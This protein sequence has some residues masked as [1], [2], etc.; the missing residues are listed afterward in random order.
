[1]TIRVALSWQP[2]AASLAQLAWALGGVSAGLWGLGALLSRRVC[3]RALQPVIRMA[4]AARALRAD[5]PGQLL[6]VAPSG[7]ELEDLGRAFNDLL[8]RLQEVLERQQRFTGDASH[9]LRTP[10]TAMLGQVEVALRQDRTPDE[11]RRVLQVVQRRAG[12]MSQLVELLLFLARMPAQA[13]LPQTRVV[14]LADWLDEHLRL[15]SDHPRA[16]D[17]RRLRPEEAP[18]G[19]VRIQPALLGQLLD[20]LLDNAC[21]YS[22]PGTPITIRVGRAGRGAELTVADRGHGI[23]PEDLPHVCDPFYRT[24]EA[25]RLGRPGV[26]LGLTVAQR[27]VKALGGELRIDSRPGEG[28]RFTV[29]LPAVR[30]AFARAC[31]EGAGESGIPSAFSREPEASADSKPQPTTTLVSG[32]PESVGAGKV[33]G[34][35][36]PG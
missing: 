29:Y 20:N 8:V 6:P 25:R 36:G 22:E 2:V 19:E 26:G 11:Y 10:L 3:R 9:Q 31:L 15:W 7:D 27:I 1:L 24:A 4:G 30:E 17:I 35:G 14:N 13:E 12:Q 32:A 23:G 5:E 18:A 28:S 34:T 21:K 33:H 16:A